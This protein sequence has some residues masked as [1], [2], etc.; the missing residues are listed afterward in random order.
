M[1]LNAFANLK[2]GEVASRTRSRAALSSVSN[3]ISTQ[4]QR[5]PLGEKP[6]VKSSLKPSRPPAEENAD[7]KMDE[8]TH[9]P[10]HRAPSTRTAAASAEEVKAESGAPEQPQRRALRSRNENATEVARPP[11]KRTQIPVPKAAHHA[12]ETAAPAPVRHEKTNVHPLEDPM[13]TDQPAQKRAKIQ[14]AAPEWDDLDAP[15]ADD[16]MMVTEY[17]G[18]IFEY[19]KELEK[20]T[21]PNANYMDDQKELA[22][23]MRGILIDWM[24]DVHNKFQLLPE[25][26]FLAINIVDRFLSLRIVS[27]IKLQLVGLTALFIAAKYEEVC[28]PSVSYFI[29]LAGGTYTD[30]EVIKAERYVLQVLD[31][32]LQYPSPLSFLRRASKADGYDIQSRTL[33][34][35]LMEVALI[36]YRCLEFPPSQVAAGSLYLARRMLGRHDWDANLVHYSG[37][38]EAELQNITALMIAYLSR[39]TKHEGLFK[40]YAARKYM[41]ASIYARDWIH[42]QNEQSDASDEL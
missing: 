16:P 22:W 2:G 31:F 27:L 1:A 28:A 4:A 33:A 6:P 34:K 13:D 20:N 23:K 29:Q 5:A 42:K 9:A 14:P 30:D 25:T 8:D 40:K 32:S 10:V 35:Y 17:V 26:L 21:L 15:E 12:A 24:I 41:K 3:N 19:M 38:R 7:P 36:E 18:E 11:V 39:P 37:Y